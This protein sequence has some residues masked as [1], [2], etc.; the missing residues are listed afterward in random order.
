MNKT[1]LISTLAILCFV[2]GCATESVN[3]ER[4]VTPCDCKKNADKV[5]DVMNLSLSL[6]YAHKLTDLN[7]ILDG[8]YSNLDSLE[9]YG[10][11]IYDYS[12]TELDSL[13]KVQNSNISSHL[14]DQLIFTRSFMINVDH[15]NMFLDAPELGFAKA[16]DTSFVKEYIVNNSENLINF[17]VKLVWDQNEVTYFKEPGYYALYAVEFQS[18]IDIQDIE[19]AVLANNS[20]GE[21]KVVNIIISDMSRDKWTEFSAKNTGEFMTIVYDHKV[22][23]APKIASLMEGNE[24]QVSGSFSEN[25]AESFAD[26]INC[27]I[28]YKD[29]GHKEFVKSLEK[30]N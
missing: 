28:L 18:I 14:I 11:A 19:K 30:C 6:N 4:A 24:I 7:L 13:K 17:D 21:G 1:A 26:F 25:E 2:A 22:I 3:N 15:E 20:N 9:N 27:K 29:M 8:L 5:E 16:D 10:D 12:K 23:L